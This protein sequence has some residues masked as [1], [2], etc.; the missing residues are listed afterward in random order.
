MTTISYGDVVYTKMENS[1]KCFASATHVIKVDVTKEEVEK[2]QSLETLIPHALPVPFEGLLDA[3]T[4]KPQ[5]RMKL[6]DTSAPAKVTHC[7]PLSLRI[8]LLLQLLVAAVEALPTF[9]IKTSE[10]GGLSAPFFWFRDS[11]GNAQ[12][13]I[14]NAAR[15]FSKAQG[16]SSS[17]RLCSVGKAMEILNQNVFSVVG[18][19]RDILDDIRSNFRTDKLKVQ[20]RKLK[21][22]AAALKEEGAEL[23][24]DKQTFKG[25]NMWQYWQERVDMALD[26]A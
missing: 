1:T 10:G 6:I 18:N 22:L 26:E 9:V 7:L 16:G 19:T 8:A 4:G 21:A 5:L 20:V 24:S 13:V 23:D 17:S 11:E 15:L 2:Y 12:F 3:D 25:P 14:M